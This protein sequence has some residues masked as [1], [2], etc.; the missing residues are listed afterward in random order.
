MVAALAISGVIV[1]QWVRHARRLADDMWR[2]AQQGGG[3]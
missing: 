1:G 2:A 3:R